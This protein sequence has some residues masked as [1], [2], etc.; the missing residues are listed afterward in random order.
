MNFRNALL[1]A[2][3]E[4]GGPVDNNEITDHIL[5]GIDWGG[6]RDDLHSRLSHYRSQ[7]TSDGLL[8]KHQH[9]GPNRPGVHEL[10]PAGQTAAL[11]LRGNND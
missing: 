3:D 8:R 10:T 9:P 1:R 4:I 11:A 2:Y 7:L 6:T 5:G